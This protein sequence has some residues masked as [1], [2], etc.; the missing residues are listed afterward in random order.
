MDFIGLVGLTTLILPGLDANFFKTSYD[1]MELNYPAKVNKIHV[2][3]L[4][5]MYTIVRLKSLHNIIYSKLEI[6]V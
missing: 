6:M 1:I 4:Q 5:T 3:K 2:L